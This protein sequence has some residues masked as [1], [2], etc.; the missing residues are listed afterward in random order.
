M[1]G[2][3]FRLKR[4]RKSKKAQSQSKRQKVKVQDIFTQIMECLKSGLDI[5]LKQ[6]V[7]TSIVNSHAATYKPIAPVDNPAQL[8]FNCSGR[9]DY[10]ID[11]NSVRLL[12]RLKLVKPDGSDLAATDKNSWSCE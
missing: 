3:G 1:T 8:E 2:S 10:Y 9:S 11:L 12:L 4:K 7:Q 5:F 6:S